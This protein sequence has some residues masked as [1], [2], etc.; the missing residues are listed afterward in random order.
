MLNAAR[1]GNLIDGDYGKEL[2]DQVFAQDW[3]L[4]ALGN[5]SGFDEDADGDGTADLAQQREHNA[6]NDLGAITTAVGADWDDSA[7]DA[8]GNM[9]AFA[10]PG[11][12]G[13]D[14]R[15]KYDAWNR[16]TQVSRLGGTGQIVLGRYE[17]DADGRRVLKYIDTNSDGSPDT[18]VH[19]YHNG[20]QVVETRVR[21]DR[22]QTVNADVRHQFFWSPHGAR[23]RSS[24]Q[25][26]MRDTFANGQPAA[27]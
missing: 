22:N 8:A 16:M 26:I 10:Q 1:R 25:L 17:Y 18:Y 21:T 12:P 20:Q 13:V 7:H 24:D 15:A 2:V 11:D 9:T 23:Q 14:L 19:F 5:W 4:D 6:A 3:N 27:R